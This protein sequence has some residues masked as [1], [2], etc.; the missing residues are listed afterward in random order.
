MPEKKFLANINF[1]LFILIF[2]AILLYLQYRLL[3][4]PSSIFHALNL[5]REIAS[6]EF[7]VK[8]LKLKNEKLASKIKFLKENPKA[9]EEQARYELG[10]KLPE[11]TYY[12]II[13]SE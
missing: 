13:F 10:M 4:S 7:E 11:E 9:Y 2:I 8:L 12:Q 6:R 1:Y 3:L 5:K